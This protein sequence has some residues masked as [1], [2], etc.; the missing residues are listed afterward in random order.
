M[1]EESMD[2]KLKEQ[3][4]KMTEAVQPFCGE[5]IIAAMTCSHSGTL[6]RTLIAKIF[7]GGFGAAWKTSGLPNPVFIAVGRENI[8]AFDYRPR[9]FKFKIKK[10]VARW[11]RKDVI[12]ETEGG[13]K[14]YNFTIA[15]PSGEK[16]PLEIPV[17]MGGKELA[18]FFID[19]IR[20]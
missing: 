4:A 13:D 12:I 8:Y 5:E 16:F 7:L 17:F 14:M 19:S 9:G 18:E 15:L 1:E 2:D 6:G 3:M 11:P 20:Q 10:E